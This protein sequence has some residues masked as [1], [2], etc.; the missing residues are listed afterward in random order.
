MCMLLTDTKHQSKG[1][2]DIFA[3]SPTDISR[4]LALTFQRDNTT[5]TGLGEE[6]TETDQGQRKKVKS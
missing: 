3:I 6:L 5:D 4:T 1:Q 2:L